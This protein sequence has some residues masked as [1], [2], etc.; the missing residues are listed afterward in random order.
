MLFNTMVMSGVFGAAAAGGAALSRQRQGGH[1]GGLAAGHCR[2][3]RQRHN[4]DWTIV[5]LAYLML[6]GIACY[7]FLPGIAALPGHG[8]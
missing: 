8:E 6:I 5:L 4:F 2:L 3:A 7:L 1:E